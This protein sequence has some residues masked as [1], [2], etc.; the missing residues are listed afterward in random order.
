MRIRHG[1]QVLSKKIMKER[2]DK[3]KRGESFFKKGLVVP[4]KCINENDWW[5]EE[6]KD[7]DGKNEHG[8]VF[9]SPC[10]YPSSVEEFLFSYGSSPAQKL[11]WSDDSDSDS[12]NTQN[13]LMPSLCFPPPSCESPSSRSGLR[14]HYVHHTSSVKS[15]KKTRKQHVNNLLQILRERYAQRLLSSI[16]QRELY[17]LWR[18]YIGEEEELLSAE[19]TMDVNGPEGPNSIHKRKEM[20]QLRRMKMLKQVGSQ[21]KEECVELRDGD[22][23]TPEIN[24]GKKLDERI[25]NGLKGFKNNS[26]FLFSTPLLSGRR[27]LI[28]LSLFRSFSF[29]LYCF[30]F[31]FCLISPQNYLIRSS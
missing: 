11:G 17:L 9:T 2:K 15:L 6:H 30:F 5:K 29:F 4:S 24:L 3:L 10:S 7:K 16:S 21:K 26:S 31:F 25:K 23:G 13:M 20:L 28:P 27:P 8:W 22:L 12:F 1:A 19:P 18:R 14:V